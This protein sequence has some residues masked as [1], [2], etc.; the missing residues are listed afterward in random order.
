MNNLPV[1]TAEI[2]DT[3]S[4][5]ATGDPVKQSWFKIAQGLRVACISDKTCR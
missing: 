1:I 5:I 3:W 4:N 2:G